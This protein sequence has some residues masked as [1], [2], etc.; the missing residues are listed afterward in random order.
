MDLVIII[1]ISA[2]YLY[3]LYEFS[4][5]AKLIKRIKNEEPEFYDHY[6]SSCSKWHFPDEKFKFI[7]GDALYLKLKSPQI[8]D[9]IVK[10]SNKNSNWAVFRFI[11]LPIVAIAM[12]VLEFIAK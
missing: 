6:F 1:T 2:I 7:V 9:E 8:K 5:S 3:W 12:F 11:L 10:R 4:W